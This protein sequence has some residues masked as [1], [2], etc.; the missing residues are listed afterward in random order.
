[1]GEV[2]VVVLLALPLGC[3]MGYGLVLCWKPLLDT[4]LYRIPIVIAPSTYGAAI[5][6]VL[7]AALVSSWAIWRRIR[8]LD[9]VRVLKTRD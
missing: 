8:H 6:V 2:A 4:E 7:A 5:L 9:L 3:L 1:L